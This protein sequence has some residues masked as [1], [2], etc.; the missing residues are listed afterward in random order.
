[1]SISLTRSNNGLFRLVRSGGSVFSFT[2]A[3]SIPNGSDTD[4]TATTISTSRIDLE[5]AINSVT[6]T[7]HSI[8]RSLDGETFD[9]LDT[10]GNGV[11]TYSDTSCDD[12]TLYYY[13]VR[14]YRDGYSNYTDIVSATTLID[15][16][17]VVYGAML[18]KPSYADMVI[19][20]E[21]I[22]ALV[23]GG[24]FARAELIDIFASHVVGES[25]INWASPGTHNPTLINS[26]SWEV[27]KG[28]IGSVGNLIN[29]NFNE[30]SDA[31]IITANSVCLIVGCLTES[32]HDAALVGGW[33][34]ASGERTFIINRTSS[35]TV[36]AACNSSTFYS[37]AN[38]LS[39]AHFAISRGSAAGYDRYIN[40]TKE[41]Q[42]DTPA[43]LPDIG[44][45]ACGW[46]VGGSA[47]ACLKRVP[48]VILLD[49]LNETEVNEVMFIMERYLDH[50]GNR[51][52]YESPDEDGVVSSHITP[53]TIYVCES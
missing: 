32:Q 2:R 9:V 7:G 8:E 12:G 33:N 44:L 3:D 48:Y 47:S 27:Y 15:E 28:Y 49:Y 34:L 53:T 51:L 52:G 26:P 36:Q 14:A 22:K 4:L 29:L 40:A 5:W 11:N 23:D 24:Y 45:Y 1:M 18:T 42:N 37:S 19:Q 6:E 38:E 10:V 50:Y 43:Y 16:Y 31:N 46:N 17:A 25:L 30:L 39:I 41:S 13:R 21:M 20:N 35:N